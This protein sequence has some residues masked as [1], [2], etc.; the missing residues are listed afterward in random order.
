MVSE[1]HGFFF[2]FT[3]VHLLH[4]ENNNKT[5]EAGKIAPETTYRGSRNASP[6]HI[7]HAKACPLHAG[8]IAF[9]PQEHCFRVL[10]SLH[11]GSKVIVFGRWE[12]C[13]RPLKALFLHAGS[14]A[15]RCSNHCF[16]NAG[17]GWGDDF[18]VHF[19]W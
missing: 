5:G 9:R 3:K 13:F 6:Q 11:L 18:C 17:R 16:C 1:L 8:S 7:P 10:K 4:S 2:L 19:V 15:F 12:H 14:I